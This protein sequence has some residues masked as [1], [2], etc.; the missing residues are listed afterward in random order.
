MREPTDSFRATRS[1]EESQII[2]SHQLWKK[3]K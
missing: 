1:E 2:R 3:G